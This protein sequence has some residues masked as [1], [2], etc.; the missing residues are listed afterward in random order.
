MLRFLLGERDLYGFNLKRVEA[1]V[2]EDLTRQ[3]EEIEAKRARREERMA[4]RNT[5]TRQVERPTCEMDASLTRE[6][7]SGN[8]STSSAEPSAPSTRL[9]A[10]PLQSKLRK[11]NSRKAAIGAAASV[12]RAMRLKWVGCDTDGCPHWVCTD[13]LPSGFDYQNDYICEHCS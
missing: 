10:K 12:P 3:Q 8:A 1:E 7:H 5:S 6:P 13:C 11:K 4:R 2:Q 9:V